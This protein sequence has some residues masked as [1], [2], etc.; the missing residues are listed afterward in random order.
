[1][2]TALL[3]CA[4]ARVVDGDTLYCQGAGRIRMAAIDAPDKV[5]SLPCRENRGSH[6]CDD[7]RAALAKYLLD[8]F[9]YGKRITYRPV[10]KDTLYGRTV[11][12]VFANGHD[13]QCFMLKLTAQPEIGSPIH[14]PVVRYMPAYDKQYGYPIQRRCPA[15]VAKAGR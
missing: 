6:V 3:L 4:A 2:L 1:M 14:T 5:N 15:I 7:E 8:R 9:S 13:L 12:Q 11:G 10:G